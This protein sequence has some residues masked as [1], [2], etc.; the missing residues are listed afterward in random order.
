MST[1]IPSLDLQRA[2][3]LSLLAHGHLNSFFLKAFITF[4]LSLLPSASNNSAPK[5][6]ICVKLHG[7]CFFKK[8]VVTIQIC[9]KLEEI[10]KTLYLAYFSWDEKSLV[11]V[12]E[13]IKIHFSYQK[14]FLR[15][16][17]HLGDS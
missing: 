8:P 6:R 5:N 2:P 12:V 10:T 7:G 1:F 11:T 13:E 4:V 16:S 3:F 14:P 9:F 15:K 17:C